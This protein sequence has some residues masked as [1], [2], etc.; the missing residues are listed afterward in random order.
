[1]KTTQRVVVTMCFIVGSVAA[2]QAQS[3]SDK[4]PQLV[5]TRYDLDVTVDYENSKL[6]STCTLTITNRS[7]E[8]VK[9]IPFTLYRLINV[10]SI[11]DENGRPMSFTQR[12]TT[13]EDWD[14]YQA[15]FIE[16]DLADPVP[17]SGK[18]TITI[19]YSGYLA[20][21]TETGMNYVR[22]KI[23]PEFTIIRPDC[24]AFPT[25]G[26]PSVQARRSA[27][28]APSFDYR[29]NVTVPD[30]LV[31][32]NGG[33]LIGRESRDGHTTYHYKNIKLA[34]RI[35]IAIAQYKALELGKLKVWYFEKDSLG[36]RNL[37]RS[38]ERTLEL[39]SRWWGA[40]QEFQGFSL[41]EIPSGFGSQADVTSILQTADAFSDSTQMGQLYHELSHLWNVSSNDKYS[42]RW[43][44][45][46]AMFAQFLTIEELERRPYL[47][48]VTGRYCERIKSDMEKDSVLSKTPV[49]DFGQKGIAGYSYSVGMMMFQ[50]L[51]RIVGQEEFND[52]VA[53]F[54]QKYRATGA[55]TDE[56]VRHS[57]KIS[58]KDLRGFF[59]DWIYTTTYAEFLRSNLSIEEIARRY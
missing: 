24:E 21:Y 36:A 33:Q 46:L 52:V 40:L 51:Y 58:K 53:S 9:T 8:S 6:I 50:V 13:F 10:R 56:F 25:I 12:V 47:E 44:E 37:L 14:I 3:Y 15:N 30:S 4:K 26:Y 34:W 2:T 22:D 45:G 20:G 31:V 27:G 38:A 32:V 39:Y 42:P 35:D 23:D 43:N 41:I 57:T 54:Y 11:R 48:K 5:P 1:M 59:N 7:N 29:L 17:A 28:A 55:T 18:K 19:D 49:I 16:V